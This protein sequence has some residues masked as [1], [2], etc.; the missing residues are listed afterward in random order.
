MWNDYGMRQL[1]LP[2]KFLRNFGFHQARGSMSICTKPPAAKRVA[3]LLQTESSILS[4]TPSRRHKEDRVKSSRGK[5]PRFNL[6]LQL[7]F[8]NPCA[9]AEAL[10]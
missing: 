7:A 4:L 5:S 8:K 2:L 6:E 9:L 3:R 1:T 10:I